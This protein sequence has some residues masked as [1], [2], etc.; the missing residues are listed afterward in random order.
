ME[1]TKKLQLE[2]QANKIR[3]D[4]IKLVYSAGSGHPGGSLSITD[5]LTYLYFEELKNLNPK[6]PK[7]P[8]RDRFVLS[9]GHCAPALY[10]TLKEKAFFTEKEMEDFRQVSGIL[11]GHPDMKHIPGIDMTTGSLGQGLSAAVRDEYSGKIR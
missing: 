5:I 11:Q 2:K 8:N 1:D 10:S 7:N 6:D 9:K 3:Q 4:I